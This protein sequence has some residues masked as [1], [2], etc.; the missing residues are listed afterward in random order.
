MNCP[1]EAVRPRQLEGRHGIAGRAAPESQAADL[2]FGVATPRAP[3]GP[4]LRA[5]FWCKALTSR[6]THR[7]ESPWARRKHSTHKRHVVNREF[8][9]DS[10]CL[11]WAVE[12][13]SR[14]MRNARRRCIGAWS[15]LCQQ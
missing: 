8:N 12:A 9:I 15:A 11:A 4:H 14:S 2:I 7:L 13:R 1:F 3:F 5:I 6:S 10:S